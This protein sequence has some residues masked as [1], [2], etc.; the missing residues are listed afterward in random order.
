MDALQVLIVDDDELNR[1]IIADMIELKN[2]CFDEAEDGL[3]ACEM[4]KKKNYDII[5]MDLMM[6]NMDGVTATNNIRKQP[7][8]PSPKIIAVTAK[9]F[10]NATK[11]TKAG[12]D[13]FI[14]KPFTED[15]ILSFLN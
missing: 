14:S 12:F 10:T 9:K 4:A 6:P 7:L 11:L 5:Y 15:Q 1:E 2:V 13:D 3:Q 8:S